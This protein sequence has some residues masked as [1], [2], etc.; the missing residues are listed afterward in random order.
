MSKDET[1]DRFLTGDGD[2]PDDP[3]ALDEDDESDGGAADGVTAAVTT[4]FWT[5]D[6]RACAACGESAPRL[7]RDGDALVCPDCKVWNGD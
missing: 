1:L 5:A 3:G 4:S 6:G 2:D 7:W